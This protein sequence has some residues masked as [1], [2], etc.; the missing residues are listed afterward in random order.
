MQPTSMDGLAGNLNFAF[1]ESVG[2]LARLPRK[3]RCY[4]LSDHEVM[5]V[6]VPDEHEVRALI[7]GGAS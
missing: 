7:G 5:V 4:S 3:D 2:S 1:D 6:E